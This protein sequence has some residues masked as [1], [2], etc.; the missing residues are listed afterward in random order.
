MSRAAARSRSTSPQGT[1]A[2]RPG[3]GSAVVSSGRR[4]RS[5]RRAGSRAGRSPSDGRAGQTRRAPRPRGR[6]RRRAGG[7]PS[8]RQAELGADAQAD[9]FGRRLDDPDRDRPRRLAPRG[10]P[11]PHGSRGPLGRDPQAGP[12]RDDGAG[13]AA[14]SMPGESIIRP[15]PPNCRARRGPSPAGRSAGGSGSGC[16]RV[17]PSWRRGPQVGVD[18]LPGGGLAQVL[19]QERERRALRRAAGLLD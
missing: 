17:H 12:R 15:T 6:A 18:A 9:M 1:R 4:R 11:I 13:S 2:A 7:P 19:G 14:S 8:D 5:A 10:E 16:A 3:A